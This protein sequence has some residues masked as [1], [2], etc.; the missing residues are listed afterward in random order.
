MQENKIQ[1]AKQSLQ[2]EICCSTAARAGRKLP[3]ACHYLKW[4]LLF[5]VN[6]VFVQTQRRLPLTAHL[7]KGERQKFQSQKTN[8]AICLDIKASCQKEF[9]NCCLFKP[10]LL[11]HHI[12]PMHSLEDT[13][14]VVF[15]Q[16]EREDCMQKLPLFS[17]LFTQ[18]FL[19]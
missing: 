18:R 17:P 13:F 7:L 2:Q 4:M 9:F 12:V 14:T 15:C 1:N 3:A 10:T 19:T 16:H 5:S 11:C 6:S 8:T